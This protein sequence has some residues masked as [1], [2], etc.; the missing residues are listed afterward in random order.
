MTTDATNEVPDADA[1]RAQRNLERCPVCNY[2]LTGLPVAHQCPECGFEYDEHTR[3][4]VRRQ[5]W[6]SL[7]KKVVVS[8]IAVLV[9]VQAAL[10]WGGIVLP[11][12]VGLI[13]GL[14]TWL[15][16]DMLEW[17]IFRKTAAAMFVAATPSGVLVKK[18]RGVPSRIP[19]TVIG[20]VTPAAGGGRITRS[21]FR[22]TWIYHQ[23]KSVVIDER[24]IA[25]FAESIAR[26]KRRHGEER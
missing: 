23:V 16:I 15:G 17:C 24:Q 10:W 26:A 7:P 12:G 14:L 13:V 22:K 5:A 11:L 2:N 6:W 19:W 18:Q 20:C 9:P 3:V 8:C 21:D 1:S 25:E 4:W